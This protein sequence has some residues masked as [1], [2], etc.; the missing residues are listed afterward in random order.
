MTMSRRFCWAMLAAAGIVLG[1][2]LNSYERISAAPPEAPDAP[3]QDQVADL[4]DHLKDIRTQV[5]EINALLHTGNVKVV[6]MINSD[7]APGAR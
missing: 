1:C 5:K 2:A 3:T 4:I 7:I 6:L